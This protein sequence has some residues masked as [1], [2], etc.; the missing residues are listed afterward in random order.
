L[1]F[2]DRSAREYAAIRAD[3]AMA[4][5]PIGPNDL[6]IAAIARSQ[7][8]TLVTNN[9]AEFSRVLGLSVAD[10]QTS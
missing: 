4:G 10:W 8:L 9:T 6:M 5:T 1:P 2:D 3:L 7:G